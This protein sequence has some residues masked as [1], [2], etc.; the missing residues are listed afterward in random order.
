M[1]Y[2]KQSTIQYNELT[3]M[4]D[5]E[6]KESVSNF[7][8]NIS[9]MVP[10]HPENC[11]KYSSHT[12]EYHQLQIVKSTYRYLWNRTVQKSAEAIPIPLR[13]REQVIVIIP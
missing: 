4:A 3:K 9:Q 12:I 13:V 5:T 2:K 6:T 11:Q 8:Q 1:P 10:S 7:R